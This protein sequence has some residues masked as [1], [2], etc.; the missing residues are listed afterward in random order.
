MWSATVA[1]VIPVLSI[2]SGSHRGDN[3]Q[4]SNAVPITPPRAASALI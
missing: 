1:S 3:I 4:S 2:A